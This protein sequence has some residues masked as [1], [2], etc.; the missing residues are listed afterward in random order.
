MAPDRAQRGSAHLRAGSEEVWM[1]PEPGGR[2]GR[3]PAADVLGT[4]G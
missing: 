1:G 3:E 2:S 4:S